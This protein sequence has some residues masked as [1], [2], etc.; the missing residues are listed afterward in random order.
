MTLKLLSNNPP[1]LSSGG[2]RIGSN[3]LTTPVITKFGAECEEK[4]SHT[5][6]IL[7]T[8]LTRLVYQFVGREEWG[9]SAGQCCR[10]WRD[11][12]AP[13]ERAQVRLLLL[14]Y[15][16]FKWWLI[17]VITYCIFDILIL[18]HFLSHHGAGH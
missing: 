18:L 6:I 15:F 7:E 3:Q 9:E 14:T 12:P 13:F 1:S 2:I 10:A 16:F 17:L 11:A 5:C 8:T 4:G